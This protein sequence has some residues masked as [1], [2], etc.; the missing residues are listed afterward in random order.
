MWHVMFNQFTFK[1]DFPLQLWAF[2]INGEFALDINISLL[3]NLGMRCSCK[4][5]HWP[6]VLSSAAGPRWACARACACAPTDK[7]PCPCTRIS[8]LC[9]SKIVQRTKGVVI[10]GLN[11]VS[12]VDCEVT[13]ETGH[14]VLEEWTSNAGAACYPSGPS[15]PNAAAISLISRPYV[16]PSGGCTGVQGQDMRV[17]AGM[18]Y[19]AVI[20][21]RWDTPRP[22][23]CS[24]HT[25]ADST[26]P[27]KRLT[28]RP[29]GGGESFG[30]LEKP[31][32][33]PP[34]PLCDIPSGCCSFT[35]PWTVTRSSL[36]M[37]RRVAAFCRP[38]RPVLLLVSFPCSRSPVVSVW[39]L[40]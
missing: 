24:A 2:N 5:L 30:A 23:V 15:A 40:R 4:P 37:L 35:G 10:E 6:H 27:Y 33:P 20:Q 28:G 26:G 32:L 13:V 11:T 18:Q 9:L 1:Q 34:P 14:R 29:V 31:Q 17:W 38:L 19:D 7:M 25:P 12:P 39:G 3:P 22:H 8:N 36:R 21:G 16:H